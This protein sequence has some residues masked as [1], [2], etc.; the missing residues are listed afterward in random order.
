MGQPTKPT[1]KPLIEHE[2][3]EV[4][5]NQIITVNTVHSKDF[6][7]EVSNFFDAIFDDFEGCKTFYEQ[8]K[9]RLEAYF[10]PVLTKQADGNYAI[11][12]QN[13]QVNRPTGKRGVTALVDTINRQRTS[14]LYDLTEY[15]KENFL[16]F[17]R[18]D[19]N[20]A[21][22]EYRYSK[23]LDKEVTVAVPK[24][25][26]QYF[27]VKS[28]P[29]NGPYRNDLI[30][31]YLDIIKVISVIYGVKDK[32]EVA[33]MK[34]VGGVPKNK[35]QYECAIGRI[36]NAQSSEYI[37]EIKRIDIGAVN[38]LTNRLGYNVVNNSIL[39]TRPRG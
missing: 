19:Q 6:E 16:S 14:K 33:K 9:I 37:M 28:I 8:G 36:I 2:V 13:E 12:V 30:V 20:M 24:N 22:T 1:L 29:V 7:T 39:M 11:A 35:Y 21:K 4:K 17:I 18:V 25:W 38:E 27:G 32:A 15:A 23:K 31:V 34:S 5:F 10:K 26:N 3:D